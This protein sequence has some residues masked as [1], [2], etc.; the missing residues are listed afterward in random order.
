MVAPPCPECHGFTSSR[1]RRRPSSKSTDGSK[2]STALIRSRL[3]SE[4]RT[5]PARGGLEL[6]VPAA[7]PRALLIAVDEVEQADS[8]ARADVQHL[9]LQGIVRT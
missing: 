9:A 5:S 1:V 2:P 4:S 8:P 3:A 6:P 7:V